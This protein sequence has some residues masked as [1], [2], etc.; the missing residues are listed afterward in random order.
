VEGNAVTYTAVKG[1]TLSST[2]SVNASTGQVT[3]TPPAGYVGNMLVKVA[4]QAAPGQPNNTGDPADSQLV[5]IAVA[6]SAPTGLDLPTASDSGSSSTDNITNATS[7]SIQVGGVTNGAVVKLFNG[8]TLLGQATSTG[9]TVT[10]PLTN[11]TPGSYSLTATQTVSNIESDR[12]TALPIVV[13]TTA[14]VINSTAPT[15][16][17]VGDAFSYNAGSPKRARRDSAM[18]SSR[19][20]RAC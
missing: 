12:S 14:P 8:T 2:V 4:V 19:R 9:T 15:T 11:V 7:L 16:A 6:P 18:N 13:D 20:P 1:D 5:S 10:I 3:A 17:R